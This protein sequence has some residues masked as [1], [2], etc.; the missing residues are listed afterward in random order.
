MAT[1]TFHTRNENFGERLN[2]GC[3]AESPARLFKKTKLNKTKKTVIQEPSQHSRQVGASGL[4]DP[5]AGRGR[6]QAGRPGVRM[7]KAKFWRKSGF[8]EAPVQ[9]APES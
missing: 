6:G 8:T 1:S 2:A 5:A 9:A 7:L 4:N 3:T